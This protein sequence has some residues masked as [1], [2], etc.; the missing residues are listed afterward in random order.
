MQFH[1]SSTKVQR[2]VSHGLV[3]MPLNLLLGTVRKIQFCSK[4]IDAIK[5]NARK[6]KS[7]YNVYFLSDVLI[8]V[9]VRNIYPL[10]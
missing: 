6:T 10:S 2:P 9:E 5:I 8:C 7:L 1:V 4:S 3:D